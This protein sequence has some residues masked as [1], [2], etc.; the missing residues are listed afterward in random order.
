[1]AGEH[2]FF[3]D[4]LLVSNCLNWLEEM[5]AW[6]YLD[7]AWDQMRFG[8]RSG[9]HPRWIGSTTPKPR[10]LIKDLNSGTFRSTVVTHASMYDNP[11]L[12]QHIRDALEE[13]YSGTQ[14]G[15]Q[16]LLG[17]ILDEDENALWTVASILAARVDPGDVP[18]LIRRSVGVDPSGGAGE[19]GIVVVGKSG[20]W[21]PPWEPQNSIPRHHGFVLDDRTCHLSPAGWGRAAIR[22]AKDH[23]AD[24]IFVE[25]NYGGD[26]CVS[27]LR[28]AAEAEGIDIPIRKVRA[29]QGKAIRAQ[30]VSAL[31]QQ[32]RWHHAGVFEQLEAQMTT[33]YP[34]LDWSPDRLDAS[35]WNAWGLNLARASALGGTG[36]IRVGK[37]MSAMG[38]VIS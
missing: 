23:Q 18:P 31:T 4:G 28:S 29:S 20:L 33:W 1:M 26:M 38:K 17:R 34:E 3:A 6:R 11:H 24:E 14:L 19:Q 12:P 10:Q 2:E 7:A 27:T 30:P 9:P 37:G 25:V 32:R 15:D 16:E 35:V 13:R 22:A 36:G 21:V 8:L 5:A